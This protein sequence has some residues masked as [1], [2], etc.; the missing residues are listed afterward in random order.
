MSFLTRTVSRFSAQASSGA[1]TFSTTLVSRKI[2][3]DAVKEPV[4]KMDRAVSD[5]LVDGIELGQTAAQKAK[6]VAGM[7]KGEV[8]GKAHEVAGEAKGKANELA[9]EAKGKKEEIKGKL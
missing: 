3:P 8:K 2:V 6:E 4:K 5:K 9:G 7:S 1:R